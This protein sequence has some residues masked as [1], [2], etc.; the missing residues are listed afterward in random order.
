[1]QFFEDVQEGLRSQSFKIQ[2]RIKKPRAF[3]LGAGVSAIAAIEV[4][5]ATAAA[6]AV[7][8]VRKADNQNGDD[9]D[10]E[11]LVVKKIAKAVHICDSHVRP[12]A[13][14]PF[15]INL[16]CNFKRGFLRSVIILCGE[17]HFV[18]HSSV[19]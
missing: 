2:K 6:A 11:A 4:A 12:K 17:H 3:R 16:C 10:P 5:A 13:E 1:M 15:V 18:H 14:L 8:A 7:A 19:R 9:D